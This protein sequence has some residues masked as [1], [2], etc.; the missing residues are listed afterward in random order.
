MRA[1]KE[2]ARQFDAQH[3]L[4]IAKAYTAFA[5]TPDL[6]FARNDFVDAMGRVG[7]GL[8][9]QA[10]ITRN[11]GPVAKTYEDFAALAQYN[12]SQVPGASS[13]G[14]GSSQPSAASG[15]SSAQDS[16]PPDPRIAAANGIVKALPPSDNQGHDGQDWAA[17]NAIRSLYSSGRPGVEARL[18]PQ[19]VKIA[20]AGLARAGY[21]PALISEEYNRSLP[22]QGSPIRAA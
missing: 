15:G 12:G 16:A 18:G 19:R 21:D 11:P 22:G 13:G 6:M 2:N 7:Q 10:A 8:S 4:D 20:Q 9:P 17:I 14:G 1:L 3:G 5:S